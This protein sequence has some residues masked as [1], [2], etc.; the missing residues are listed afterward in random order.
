M[1]NPTPSVVDEIT[2]TLAQFQAR[3]GQPP[4][5]PDD[6]VHRMVLE[7]RDIGVLTLVWFTGTDGV[8]YRLLEWFTPQ[9][10]ARRIPITQ[11]AGDAFCAWWQGQ[12]RGETP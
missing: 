3:N 1:L 4:P 12:Q 6:E 10:K 11:A 8:P 9:A 2:A 5:P 7:C